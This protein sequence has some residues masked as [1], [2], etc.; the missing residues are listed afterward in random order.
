MLGEP[1]LLILDEPTVGLDPV[2]RQKMWRVF[3]DMTKQG[4]TI[5][6]TS[7]DMTEADKCHSLLFLRDGKLMAAGE[8]EDILKVTK[9][10]T[11]ESA[12]LKLSKVLEAK[13]ER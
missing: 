1:E 11:T 5:I 3:A 6:V 7:H 10:K 13:H 9:S 4:T 2:L 12:F 8:R